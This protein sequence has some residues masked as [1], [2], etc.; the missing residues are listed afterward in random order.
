MSPAVLF[1]MIQVVS[2]WAEDVEILTSAGLIRG[3]SRDGIS[4]FF[5]IPYAQPPIGALRFAPPLPARRWSG[6]RN[7]KEHP[8]MC[9]QSGTILSYTGSEDCLYLNAFIPSKPANASRPVIVKIH[10][11][12]FTSGSASASTN[13]T[14]ATGVVVFA[15]QYRLGIFGFFSPDLPPPN[16]GM[17]DQQ[18]ALRWVQQNAAA[19]GG[20]PSRVM[21][22]GCSAGG[23]S[24]AGHLVLPGSFGLFSSASIASPGGH[25]GWMGD[26][27]RVDDDWMSPG[28]N[29]NH[30]A[31]TVKGLSCSRSSVNAT[32]AC[33][34][35]AS[36]H[37]LFAFERKLRFAPA[38]PEE[39]QCPLGM[40]QRGQWNQ[41]PTMI[42]GASCEA[43]YSAY[44]ILGRSVSKA[45]F[46]KGLIKYGLSGVNGSGVGPETLEKWYKDRI[47]HEGR[48]RSFARI[49]GDSGHSCSTALHAEALANTASHRTGIWRYLFDITHT[50]LPGAPHCSETQYLE[51]SV[52]THSPTEQ[53]LQDSL[54][55][56]I[57]N[58][59]AHGDP[60][61]GSSNAF[62]WS[63]FT[64]N[65]PSTL[66]ATPAGAVMNSTADTVR[67]ECKNWKPYLGWGK[68]IV[69]HSTI[70][71]LSPPW[72]TLVV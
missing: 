63:M 9:I 18:L 59:A 6:V 32:L 24:V 15:I 65:N 22:H 62:H 53:W 68:K 17:Q 42:G 72:A 21:I 10:G 61:A 13:L 31:R 19:F 55:Q 71:D 12:S 70:S 47:A 46:D 30:S 1:I 44:K 45:T 33:L 50:D 36:V 20:N 69:R 57:T 43:C 58:L 66:I 25:Q 56:W 60:N 37:A 52:R 16:F 48:W 11:G 27:K 38:L 35:H 23:A 8:S 4:S 29:L 49:L 34:Q 28:L 67:A 7:A 3:V 40:I 5:G 14:R 54:S 39:G 41:V 2:A 64:K 26:E 51:H